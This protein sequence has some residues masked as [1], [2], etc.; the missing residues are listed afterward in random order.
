M[1]SGELRGIRFHKGMDSQMHQQFVDDIMLMGDP[2][3]QEACTFKRSLN[4]FAKALG[5]AVN[6]NKSQFFFL[7][8]LP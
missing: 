8:Q 7:T 1:G 6:A 2:S 5:L 4:L 3:V